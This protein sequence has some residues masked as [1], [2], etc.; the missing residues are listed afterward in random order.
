[1]TTSQE[2]ALSIRTGQFLTNYHDQGEG[3]P[4]LL[5]HGSGPGVSAWANWRRTLPELS[6]S[7]RV[8]APDM[9]G[10]GFTERPDGVVY[11]LETWVQQLLD[12]LDSL[13]LERVHLVGNSFGGA[14]SLAFTLAYPQRVDKLALMGSVGLSFP[15][16]DGLDKVWGYEPDREAMRELINLFAFDKSIATPE[17]VEMRYQASAPDVISRS[18]SS[19]FPAPRQRWLEALAQPEDRLRALTHKTLLIHGRDDQ[20][21]PLASSQRLALLL[22]NSQLH[23][24]GNCGHWVQI[25]KTRDF[26]HLLD[27]FLIQDFYG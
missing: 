6:K 3:T 13:G 25:E 27:D 14:V 23:V 16:T 22:P 1:M 19:M 10:F 12:L 15:I 2:I 11:R 8:I 17:L 20:I 21:I 24:F 7:C 26:N 9:V 18:Y 4:V 5:I